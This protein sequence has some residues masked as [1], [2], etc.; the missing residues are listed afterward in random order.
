[1][2]EYLVGVAARWY[3]EIKTFITNWRYFQY[4]FLTKFALS[5]RKNTWYF[6]YKSCKQVGQT[7]DEYAINFQANWRKINKWKIML[8]DSILADFMS[9]L[10]PNISMLL[11][12][13][14][15]HTFLDYVTRNTAVSSSLITK[16]HLVISW[17]AQKS[18]LSLDFLRCISLG[19]VASCSLL[20]LN[21]SSYKSMMT[22]IKLRDK[23]TL[24]NIGIKIYFIW[25]YLFNIY[26]LK[27]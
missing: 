6:K 23:C 5:A 18:V 9:G 27:S 24:Y 17:P 7:I 8:A 11:T 4:V 20:K 15:F 19:W 16:F 13:Q 10:D 12:T 1:M 21:K 26:Y 3:D 25:V 14:V 22:L 2:K